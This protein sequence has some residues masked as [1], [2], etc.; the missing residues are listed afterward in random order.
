M[1]LK[2]MIR[3][4]GAGMSAV[5]RRSPGIECAPERLIRQGFAISEVGSSR[6]ANTARA[7]AVLHRLGD[8][9]VTVG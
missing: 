5:G 6:Q 9:L 2:E 1:S 4:L 3:F 8:E 7:P